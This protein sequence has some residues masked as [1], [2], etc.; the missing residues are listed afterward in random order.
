MRFSYILNYPLRF[1]GLKMVRLSRLKKLQDSIVLSVNNSDIERDEV[2]LVLYEKVKNYTLVEIERC[3]ALYKSVKY[4]LDNNIKGD[5][6]DCGVWKGGS[7]MLVAYML[8]AAGVN[9]RKI[10][11]YDT[12]E[13]MTK[14]GDNDGTFEK[15]EWER[16]KINEQTNNWC[17]SSIEEVKSNMLQTGYPGTNIQFIK[18][19]VEDTIPLIIPA[20]IALLRLDTDWYESTKH[21]L[22]HLY[23]LL[24]SKGVLIIDDYGAWEG[25][26]KATDEYFAGQQILL[27]RIDYTGRL[28]IK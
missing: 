2:F 8:K 28:V 23:P 5:F 18:G 17:L 12:F 11:L 9:D 27:N 1:L 25:A 6:V 24:A 15:E 14:P 7:C 4:I 13:G 19:K 3:Y 16:L 20:L 22:V 21:E 26:R 10:Y